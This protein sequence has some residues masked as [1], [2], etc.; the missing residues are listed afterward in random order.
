MDNTHPTSQRSFDE[1][2]FG[3]LLRQFAGSE[4]ELPMAIAYLTQA[5]NDPDALRKSSLVRIAREKIKHANIVG[6]M[7][8]QMTRGRT[9][10]LS[11][12]FDQADLRDLLAKEGVQHGNI[13]RASVLLKDFNETRHAQTEGRHY[14]TDPMIYLKANI[15]TE[16]KQ[17]AAYG[18]IAALT[19]DSHFVSALNYAKSRQIQHRDEFIDLLRRAGEKVP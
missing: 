17:I 9:G 4:G 1:E 6:A 10:A 18:Q 13:E 8:L 11:T 12:R 3:L 2:L 16:E 15:V 14:A 5:T 7:L 19:L